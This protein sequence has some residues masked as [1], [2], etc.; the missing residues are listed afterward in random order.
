M[1]RYTTKPRNLWVED[2]DAWD[3]FT[4]TQ[5]PTVDD[6]IPV[7]TGLLDVN[8]DPIFRMPNPMGFGKDDEW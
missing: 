6:H 5:A 4:Q 1:P 8:G 7:A 3:A 2:E